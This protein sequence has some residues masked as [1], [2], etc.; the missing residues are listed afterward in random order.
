MSFQQ[1]LL[2]MKDNTNN[3]GPTFEAIV[4]ASLTQSHWIRSTSEGILGITKCSLRSAYLSLSHST[5]L[6]DASV[7]SLLTTKG[8]AAVERTH[9]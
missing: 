5:F 7:L 4:L 2:V 6:N 1:V 9:C 3:A 8:K